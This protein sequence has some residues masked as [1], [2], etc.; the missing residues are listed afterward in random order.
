MFVITK[1]NNV[2][3]ADELQPLT[4][5]LGTQTALNIQHK[6]ELLFKAVVDFPSV[7]RSPPPLLLPGLPAFPSPP[8]LLPLTH[9]Q[10]DRAPPETAN[11]HSTD[12][13]GDVQ[14]PAC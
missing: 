7:Y 13:S 4:Y 6:K 14:L 12:L 8:P 3:F 2:T 10:A 1:E 5:L 9:A 11:V